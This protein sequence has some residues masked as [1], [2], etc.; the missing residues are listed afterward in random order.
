MNRQQF[1][2]FAMALK[3]YYP[4]ENI[5]P[6]NQAMEL[7]FNQLGDLDY[8][9]AQEVLNNWVRKSKWSPSIAE[10]LKEAR[11]IEIENKLLEIQENQFLLE[12]KEA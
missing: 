12:D 8:M 4:K 7:W 3:T 10:I 2:Q 11:G 9:I 5:L 6:N 1:G